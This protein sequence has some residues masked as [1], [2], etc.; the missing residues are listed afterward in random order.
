MDD[1]GSISGRGR[2]FLLFAPC[3]QTG[4]GAHPASYPRGSG[5]SFA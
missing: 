5:N 4:S 2:D 1:G 3:V